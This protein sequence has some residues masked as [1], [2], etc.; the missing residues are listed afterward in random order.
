MAENDLPNGQA[1][2]A[3]IGDRS[4]TPEGHEVHAKDLVFAQSALMENLLR[5]FVDSS[6]AGVAFGLT[7]QQATPVTSRVTVVVDP[8]GS[9]WAYTPSGHLIEIP[10][11]QSN[12]AL[13]DPA[14]GIVNLICAIYTEEQ[15]ENSAHETDGVSRPT[16]A[17]R[18][19][20]IRALTEVE[21]NAL[22]DSSA[23]L[24]VDAKDRLVVLATV[25]GTGT[26]LNVPNP[27]VAADIV[28]QAAFKSVLTAELS[29]S[30]LEITGVEIID[31]SSATDLGT[32]TLTLLY[33]ISVYE[34]RWAAPG[35]TAGALVTVAADGE[36]T[37][38]S[39]NTTDSI[40]VRVVFTLLP[41]DNGTY[42]NDYALS[43]LYEDVAPRWSPRDY[44]HASKV[45][46]AL[47]TE[48]NPHGTGAE[49]LGQHMIDFPQV[50]RLGSGY[51]ATTEQG[52]VPR[53]TTEVSTAAVGQPTL[54]WE[55]SGAAANGLTRIYK[56]ATTGTFQLTHNARWDGT[57]WVKDTIAFDSS[58]FSYSP[59]GISF[60][61][62]DSVTT[63]FAPA[64]ITSLW[65]SS[66]FDL[67]T[68]QGLLRF[69]GLQGAVAAEAVRPRIQGLFNPANTR[70]LMAEFAL[71]T[72]TAVATRLY[73]GT[74]G[75][76]IATNAR[77]DGTNFN[78]DYA[79][80]Q[81]TLVT[82]GPGISSRTMP[83]G[84]LP[85]PTFAAPDFIASGLSASVSS[86]TSFLADSLSTL[87]TNSARFRSVR[88]LTSA[89][90]FGQRILID[91]FT[92]TTS[93][94]SHR[95]YH[96]LNN[97][98]FQTEKTIGCYWDG[99]NWRPDTTT[100]GSAILF[101][102]GEVAGGGCVKYRKDGPFLLTDFWDQTVVTGGW[103]F[104]D[105]AF[106][107]VHYSAPG[108]VS[109]PTQFNIA[110]VAIDGGDTEQINV[111]FLFPMQNYSVNV[112][113]EH[114][115]PFT[116]GEIIMP[117]IFDLTDAGFSFKGKVIDTAAFRDFNV[118]AV[119]SLFHIQVQGL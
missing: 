86:D 53:V 15:S 105:K 85:W 48:T 8:S 47:P 79:S 73:V 60:S 6:R 90:A 111:T 37:L 72:G 10:A 50:I 28:Q 58:F 99:A 104:V 30:P 20:R 95:E 80:L 22:P 21:Y 77:W 83:P 40:T 52:L 98:T 71:S 97:T 17:T 84:T 108:V 118:S 78:Q 42:V 4:L 43:R 109:L 27:L 113:I 68:P 94:V 89:T 2:D 5:R 29:S 75:L 46:A 116:S 88:A 82:I 63:P 23:D 112:T 39:N 3:S 34:L 44:L 92:D 65:T 41:Q 115:D 16:R 106:G 70:T 19:F 117:V 38:F 74:N 36:Y 26:T 32:G 114:V 45:G 7:V 96:Y 11:T 93:G 110:S 87:D 31:I 57:Q 107:I 64:A 119:L 69:A 24:S 55:V 61:I 49:D 67:S 101:R 103:D 9:G 76:E 35:D 54:L 51:M 59:N 91:Q 66:I 81:S 56:T 62:H 12:I 13:A 18:S 25:P 1:T 102:F 33:P 14:S 100:Q